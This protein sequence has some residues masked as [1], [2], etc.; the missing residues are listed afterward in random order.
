[1]SGPGMPTLDQM[2]VLL[3]IADTGSLAAA[4]RRLGR[5]PSVVSYALDNLENQLGLSL[6]ERVTTR[7]PK[8]T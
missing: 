8:L 7:H 3:A 6:F 4:A 1:M 2:S 5:A